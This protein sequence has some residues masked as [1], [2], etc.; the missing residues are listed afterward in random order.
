LRRD[1]DRCQFLAAAARHPTKGRDGDQACSPMLLVG[2]HEL[3]GNQRR[4]TSLTTA[5]GA[6]VSKFPVARGV[7]GAAVLPIV[8]AVR[9]AAPAVQCCARGG[10][11]IRTCCR[12]TINERA[13]RPED[14]IEFDLKQHHLRWWRLAPGGRG[15]WLGHE[16]SPYHRGEV[17]Q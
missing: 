17:G 13:Y 5:P 4:Y 14:S 9:I 2:N 6:V 12:E 10:Q 11:L 15:V 16:P 8:T 3:I 1:A 7:P